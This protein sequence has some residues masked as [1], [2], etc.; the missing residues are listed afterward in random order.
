VK[1]LLLLAL[2]L[3]SNPVFAGQPKTF[4]MQNWYKWV[5]ECSKKYGVDPNIALAVA[6][7]ESSIGNT[8]FRFGKISKTLYGPFGIR[9]C[10][11]KKWDITD[12]FVN[13]EVGI[14]ALARYPGNIKR[15]LQKYNKTFNNAYYNRIIELSKLNKRMKVFN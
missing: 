13:T 2:L 6:E 1:I 10:F 3:I 12:P 9:D 15:S 4:T 14:R 11:L 8:R 5:A 7:T